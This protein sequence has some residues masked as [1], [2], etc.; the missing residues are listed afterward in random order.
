MTEVAVERSRAIGVRGPRR[1]VTRVATAAL[2]AAVFAGYLAAMVVGLWWHRWNGHA[3]LYLVLAHVVLSVWGYASIYVET[4]DAYATAVRD[5]AQA[6]P[7]WTSRLRGYAPLTI[8][9]DDTVLSTA[10]FPDE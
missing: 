5:R 8:L 4:A 2:L 6:G 10:A 1:S 9:A 3:C 7:R